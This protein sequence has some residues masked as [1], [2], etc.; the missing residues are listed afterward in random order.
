MSVHEAPNHIQ[1]IL[2]TLPELPGVYQYFDEAGTIIY[3]GK[4]KNLRK[5]VSSYFTKDRY[6]S[7]KTAILVRKIT[8]IKFIV[9]EHEFD[10]LLLENNLIKEYQPRYNILLKDDKTYPWIC[11]KKEPFARVFHT[12]NP[13]RDGSQYFGPYASGKGM[14]TLLDLIRQLYPIRT[15]ALNLN[16]ANI[17]AGKFKLCLE[18]HIGNCK[19]PCAGLQSE[20]D[21]DEAIAQIRKILK[22]NVREVLGHLTDRMHRHA[23]DLEFEEAQAVKEK[24]ASIEKYQRSSVVVSPYVTGVDVLSVVSDVRAGYVNFMRVVEGAIIHSHTVELKKRLEE[25]DRELL[26]AA[27]VDLRARYGDETKEYVLPFE[28]ELEIPGVTFTVPQRG[29][30]AKLLKLSERNAQT[31]KRDRDK[32]QEILDPE[33]SVNRIMEQMR[34]DLRMTVQPRHI[35]CF[36]NS[37]IQGRFAVAA[38]VCF[39]DG[40]PAKKDYRH[41]NIKSVEG[42]DDFASMRE[43]I[44]RRYSRLVEEGQALPQLIIIDGGKGQLSSAVEALDALHLRGK[45]TVVGI[46]KRLEEIY[47]PDDPLPLYIDKRSESLRIIQQARNEAHRFGI[48]HHRGKRSKETIRTALTDIPGIGEAVS[49]KLLRHFRSVKRIREATIEELTELIGP[50]KAKTVQA[51]LSGDQNTR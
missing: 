30:R 3:V 22:G 18:Y 47:F 11:I 23:T 42:P 19:G 37:N 1:T 40:K 35:E 33:N 48:T 36:D 21:H 25:T 27:L 49:Q 50:A 14:H 39:R 9:T 20:T 28:V 7:R 46:A 4:A 51:G 38:M 17:K 8:D 6:D 43:V 32:Q 34:K 5:R 41:F 16:A 45:M 13:V 12:R 31:Y 24:I 10:A 44:T 29:D 26:E 15:C 2:R